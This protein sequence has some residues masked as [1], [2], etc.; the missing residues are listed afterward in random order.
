MATESGL[1][2]VRQY[3]DEGRNLAM[4]ALNE[5]N[6]EAG[7][8]LRS[9]WTNFIQLV[10]RL[11][12]TARE[13]LDPT[14]LYEELRIFF[15]DEIA[16][17]NAFA[18]LIGLGFG[19]TGGFMLGMW[20]ARPHLPTPIMKSI[21]STSFRDPDNVVVC[22][23][24]VP[25]FQS[26]SDILVRVRAA[27][28]NRIDRRIAFG[29]GRTLR[30]MIR[31]YNSTYDPELPL[32]LGRS[33]AGIVE[34][35]GNGS[36]SG[37]EIGDEV[38]LATQWYEPG[39]ASE[40]V[41]V[42][43]TRVS[44]KPFLIGFEGAASLPYSGSI[45][46]NLLDTH[47]LN[48]HTSKGKRILVQDACSP[49]GCVITQ[50]AHKWGAN[51]AATCHTR[52]VPVINNLGAADIITFAN[53]HFRSNFIDVN[54]DKSNFINEL[55]S[56]E[57][58]NFIF[59]TTRLGYDY[60]FLEKFLTKDGVIVDAVEPELSTDEY[61]VV[62]RFF[63]GTY[64]RCRKAVAF[65][66]RTNVDWGGP[67]LCHLVLERLAGFVNDESLKT[68]VDR[69]YTPNE[70]ERALEHICSEKSIGSTIITFR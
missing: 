64:V 37:L 9:A 34:A 67:H 59:L 12:T 58:F 54:V 10:Q 49:V 14:V 4:R 22:Q 46:L 65:L 61:G 69:V 70:V 6:S 63:L 17:N 21:A 23:T 52:S 1:R 55:T 28:L 25:Q 29:Y 51:V 45:A 47:R 7:T 36:K 24:A 3:S 8:A 20:L 43:E 42:P 50:L 53:E 62:G 27:S 39:V 38:W 35:V 16:R 68:L 56:R 48:E 26:S 44:R 66:F 5:A 33:C 32:V 31:S 60:K 41:V 2:V 15:R 18:I 13:V 57:K 11:K 30:R 40:F 19:T